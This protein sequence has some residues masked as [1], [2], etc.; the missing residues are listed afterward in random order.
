[1]KN[2]IL[3]NTALNKLTKNEYD[4]YNILQIYM[5]KD[6]NLQLLLSS[7][8]AGNKSIELYN[9][10]NELLYKKY[11]NNIINKKQYQN[12]INN[13]IIILY[14]MTELILNSNEHKV[15]IN[16]LRYEL[17]SPI[18]FDNSFIS[19]TQG[20]FY[21]FFHNVKQ[22]Y[23][24]KVKKDNTYYGISFIISMLEVEDINKIINGELIG[25]KLLTEDDP[26]IVSIIADI[27]TFKIIILLKRGY[28]LHLDDNFAHMLGFSYKTLKKDLQ[29]SDKTPQINWINYLKI[30]SNIIDN[31]DNPY[32]L[33]NIFIKSN[34]SELTVYNE[35]NIY[36]KQ[37]IINDVFNYIE[38]EI[39][40]EKIKDKND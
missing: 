37:K 34:V 6:N 31:K 1:M 32:Y 38:I 19:L 14:I 4:V 40:D 10:I 27:N 39:L 17:K 2:A 22:G 21:N 20:V 12:I 16:K 13:I 29:R 8:L 3:K 33:S 35:N 23:E 24:M 5:K 15:D 36:E 11:R 18:R 26:P 7:Y 30:Y 28:E 9:K 25:H